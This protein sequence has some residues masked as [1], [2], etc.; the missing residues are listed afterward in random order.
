MDT[1]V[2]RTKNPKTAK[3]LAVLDEKVVSQDAT[4]QAP[5]EE[6][7]EAVPDARR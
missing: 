7:D 6:A 4:H 1:K 3:H 2:I 5:V